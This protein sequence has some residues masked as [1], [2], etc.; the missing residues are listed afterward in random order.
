MLKKLSRALTPTAV[1][2]WF[3]WQRMLWDCPG[4]SRADLEG[5]YRQVTLGLDLDRL[6]WLTEETR[7]WRQKDPRSPA[8][9]YDAGHW[10]RIALRNAAFLELHRRTELRVLDVGC[11]PGWFMAACRHFGHDVDGLDLPYAMMDE[12]SARAYRDLT[13]FLDLRD[14]VMELRIEAFTPMPL[15][16]DYD[17]IVAFLVCFNNH[18]QPDTWGAREWEFFLNDAT[19]RLRPGGR[20]YMQLNSDRPRFGERVFYDAETLD[21]FRARGEVKGKM[22]DIRKPPA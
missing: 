8:K 13:G 2:D 14:R 20:L 21:L 4:F 1:R 22:V 6:A 12:V 15:R 16:Q 5:A 17:L 19:A 3:H 7:S 11:G 18:K 9:Y 10:L